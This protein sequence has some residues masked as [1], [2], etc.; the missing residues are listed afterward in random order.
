MATSILARLGYLVSPKPA[1]FAALQL[2]PASEHILCETVTVITPLLDYEEA[3]EGWKR[4]WTSK[5]K[6]DFLTDVAGHCSE[7]FPAFAEQLLK[8]AASESFDRWWT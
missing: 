4:A 7:D 5:A 1:L 2:D 6:Q 3:F 8:E